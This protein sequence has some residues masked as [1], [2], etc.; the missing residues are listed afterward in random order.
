MAAPKL[1]HVTTTSIFLLPRTRMK[2]RGSFL[3]L[4]V[5]FSADSEKIDP[6]QK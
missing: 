3:N 4:L 6:T 5:R 1:D 2:I